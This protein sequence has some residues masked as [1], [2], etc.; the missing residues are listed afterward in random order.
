MRKHMKKGMA[1]LAVFLMAF[2]FFATAA[3]ADYY[4]EKK[5]LSYGMTHS[6][7]SNLQKDLKKLG[8]FNANATGY[9]GSIT[10]KAAIAYQKAK[11]LS[12]DGIVGPVTA[13]SI[14]VDRVIQTAK[15]YLG[16]PYVWGGSTT[17]GFDCSG[18]TQYVLKQNSIAVPRTA[19]QQY[20]KG[21]AVSKSKL[22]P[23]D[24]VFFSTYKP[25]A[26]HLGIYLG[27]DQFIHASSGSGK[28]IISKLSGSY[29]T[30]HYL[31]AKRIV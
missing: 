14:K 26:S 5:Q 4:T 10:K 27:K 3:R 18:F 25:G 23:G 13:H 8:Y 21:T 9:Y 22:K 17:A 19:A 7:V 24:L 20:E 28:V 15:S 31:G 1:I 6:E 2:T 16:T 11:S 29:Y 30:Q 12:A